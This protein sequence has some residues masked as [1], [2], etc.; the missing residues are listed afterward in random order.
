MR[1]KI[2]DVTQL[3]LVKTFADKYLKKNGGVG[4]SRQYIENLLEKK[5]NKGFY[6]VVIDGVKFI[7]ITDPKIIGK[8]SKEIEKVVSK[9]PVSKQEKQKVNALLKNEELHKELVKI[10]EQK[11][12]KESVGKKEEH[13]KNQLSMF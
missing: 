11:A 1:K 7:S 3:M 10:S 13:S 4:V 8:P 2:Y 12:T 6:A 5:K 9:P